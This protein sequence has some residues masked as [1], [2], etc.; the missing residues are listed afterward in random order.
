MPANARIM[1]KMAPEIGDDIDSLITMNEPIAI[2]NSGSRVKVLYG[3]FISGSL[4][5]KTK[6]PATVTT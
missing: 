1:K 2:K 5:R 4:Y 3:R 6:T